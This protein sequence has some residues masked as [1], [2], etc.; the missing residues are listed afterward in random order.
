LSCGCVYQLRPTV[1]KHIPKLVC[2]IARLQGLGEWGL[3]RLVVTIKNVSDQELLISRSFMA[4]VTYSFQ[5]SNENDLVRQE[6]LA[7]FAMQDENFATVLPNEEHVVSCL[8][9]E[10]L[11]HEIISCKECDVVVEC[12]QLDG[13]RETLRIKVFPVGLEDD[14]SDIDEAGI[15]SL[16]AHAVRNPPRPDDSGFQGAILE[17]PRGQVSCRTASSLGVTGSEL[18]AANLRLI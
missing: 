12:R 6:S 15:Y 8:L 18:N 5:G 11:V 4:V 16:L 3:H 14:R 13:A 10:P 1:E 9:K 17:M 7:C 2:S